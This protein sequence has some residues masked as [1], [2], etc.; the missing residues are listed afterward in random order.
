M[1]RINSYPRD[2][3]IGGSEVLLGSDT[4]GSTKTFSI[5]DLKDFLISK[6]VSGTVGY[7]FDNTIS[8]SELGSGGF[9][10]DST[11]F[12][13]VTR[14]TI[15]NSYIGGKDVTN[16]LN[17]FAGQEVLIYNIKDRNNFARYVFSGTFTDNPNN[18]NLKNVDVTYRSSNGDFVGGEFYAF[19]FEGKD[20]HYTHYQINASAS[21][22]INHNMN[23]FPSVSIKFSSSDSIYTN[24]GALAGVIYTDKNNLTINLVSSESGYAYLN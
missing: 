1:A 8:D 2:L 21:W 7:Q 5:N 19:G 4:D 22:V 20:R 11:T 15:H 10:A 12:S 17:T 6:G 18:P 16:Y 13:S 3:S 9:K 23:K 14:I 24:V